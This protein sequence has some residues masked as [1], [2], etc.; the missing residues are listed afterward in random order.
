MQINAISSGENFFQSQTKSTSDVKS[1]FAKTL[2]NLRQN[3][4]A[5]QDE[6]TQN[7]NTQTMIQILSDGSTLVTVYDE[8]GHIISQNKTRAVQ[9]DPNAHIIG[10]ST[11]K[12]FGLEELQAQFNFNI[13]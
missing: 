12:N 11:E 5:N 7:Q 13:F 9:S 1:S 8:N 10:T 2:E 4:P 3:K 6:S